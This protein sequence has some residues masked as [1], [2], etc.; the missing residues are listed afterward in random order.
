MRGVADIDEHTLA[1]ASRT[2]DGDGPKHRRSRRM[3]GEG[4]R[5]HIA[6]VEQPTM[7]PMIAS[8]SLIVAGIVGQRP[9]LA[10]MDVEGQSGRPRE[11][12]LA[13]FITHCPSACIRRSRHGAL[14][15]LTMS[16]CL[17]D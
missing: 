3:A 6:G 15:P 13:C 14:M 1:I 10:E 11:I 2:S 16:R 12:S 5:Q 8:A 7:S 4:M 9:E 17:G